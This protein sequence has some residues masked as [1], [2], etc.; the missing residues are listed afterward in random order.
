MATDYTDLSEWE[1]N[2]GDGSWNVND[3]CDSETVA[4]FPDQPSLGFDDTAWY[5]AGW[6]S[7]QMGQF[8]LNAFYVFEK[9]NESGQVGSFTGLDFP[10]D[11]C[12]S[13]GGGGQGPGGTEIARA[14]E[15]YDQPQ[16]DVAGDNTSDP[17]PTLY[18]AG[19]IR[20]KGD[21]F[22]PVQRPNNIV[23][24]Y[25]IAD[26]LDDNNRTFHTVDI[27]IACFDGEVAYN[28]P[29]KDGGTDTFIGGDARIANAGYREDGT[30]GFLY[31]CHAVADSVVIDSSTEEQIVVRW[32][33]IDMNGWPGD[34]ADDPE[35]EASGEIDG[36]TTGDPEV[37]VH[38]FLPAISVN[39][40]HD[41]AIVMQQT[42]EDEYVSLQGWGRTD[43]GDETPLKELAIG[44]AGLPSTQVDKWGDYCAAAPAPDGD[45]WGVI[46]E[47]MV[48]GGASADFW[49]T[50]FRQIEIE[51]P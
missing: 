14:V 28:L 18:W 34:G 22:C 35:I 25:S 13:S 24:I 21:A 43:A 36:G 49:V 33:K 50:E 23:R 6:I 5:V 10:G 1:F 15:Y 26:P 7:D 8:S 39:D 29:V 40:G 27:E 38:L 44:D 51:P 46:G 48:D 45:R 17:V 47:V 41:I 31:F 42:S 3:A 11:N 32:Y 16:H 20:D 12:V 19:A 9:A 4:G 2:E 37:P 30:D